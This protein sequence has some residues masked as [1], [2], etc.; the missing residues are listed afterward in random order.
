LACRAAGS[1]GRPER[2]QEAHAV[3]ALHDRAG[4]FPS[5]AGPLTVRLRRVDA[6]F[7]WTPTF[8]MPLDRD[9][10]EAVEFERFLW[11][12]C[13]RPAVEL[14]AAVVARYPGHI[15]C[16]DIETRLTFREVWAAAVRLAAIVDATVAPGAAVGV[17]LPN[18]AS[19]AVA[20]LACLGA[21][22]PCI[23]ID[24]NYPQD[25]VGRIVR[26]AGL[27]AIVLR[28]SEIAEGYLLPA[29]LKAI[30]LEQAFEPGAMLDRMPATPPAPDE[31]TFVVYT[32]GSTGG[33]KGIVLSQRAVLHRAAE[34]VNAVHL[35]PADK[36]LSLASPGTIGGLQQIFEVM[37]S[38]ASLVKLDL[39]RIGLGD[40]VRI[41]AERR[42]TMMFSTP[43]V[44][45]SVSRLDG[46]AEKLASLR[47][48][49][50]SGDTLLRIDHD[51]IRAI[52]P[53]DCHVLSVYGATEAPALLQWFVVSP[54]GDEPRVPAGYPL[55]D[56]ELAL[57]DD[58][59]RPVADGGLGEL[60]VRS[61]FTSLGL[62]QRGAVVPGVLEKD[63]HF[64]ELRLYRTGDLVRRR[65]DGLHVVIGRRDR[66]I[67]ILGNRVELAEVETALRQAP[68][69]LDAAAVA[70]RGEGEPLILGFVVPRREDDARVLEDV[71]AHLESALPGFMRPRK[72]L[73]LEALPLLPG[74]KIDEDALLERAATSGETRPGRTA[75][76]GDET[77]SQRA[78]NMV[79]NAWRIAL[80][81]A[82]PR[83]KASFEEAGGDSLQ[84]LQM[85]FELE[86]LAERALPMERFHGG[87]TVQGIA[88]E[89][90][91]CL[92]AP[93]KTLAADTATIFMFPP[94]GIDSYLT[95]FR[96]ACVARVE[97]RQVRYPE[98]RALAGPG[99]SFETIAAGTARQIGAMKPV[100]R[101]ILAGYSDGGD[102][103]YAAAR[104]L[105]AGGRDVARL[106]ILDTD[107]SGVSYAAP[108][109]ERTRGRWRLP[110]YIRHPTIHHYRR[111]VE[112]LV[113]GRLLRTATGRALLRCVLA[114]RLPIPASI[115][116]ITSL[117]AYMVVFDE[118]HRRWSGEA[119]FAP[120][121]VPMVLFRS[122]ERRPGTPDDLGWRNRTTDLT[123]VPVPG[124]HS[125][126]LGASNG[127][128]LAQEFARLASKT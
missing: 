119:D 95:E 17:L 38:G 125:T 11:E 128:A 82:P 16:E 81:L 122:Q 99:M 20:V 49:Q 66:Q 52:L 36:V 28:G 25:R 97:V 123:I 87:L 75:A 91:L 18:Q 70:R 115:A 64:P 33:P 9:G 14:F 58:A 62:W 113:P 106:L 126:M 120:L 4:T 23:L 60:V 55:P 47:C 5:A 51:Q 34:L 61:R 27:A 96:A 29:G 94:I 74:R 31:A 12:W 103:A 98:L 89:I 43:A 102:M 118:H 63:P 112:L 35:R 59:G 65:P 90:D 121:T 124:D 32:S 71:R 92:G 116:F 41:V 83:T 117:K 53:S 101:L 46:V 40:V 77:P 10:P 109:I 105:Q 80:G 100:G 78:I 39:Q 45:R 30:A 19:Y 73:A 54:P 114:F 67:K 42:I 79:D 3:W 50:S 68:G 107:A 6:N 127:T 15:A 48:I 21:A 2:L 76:G 111:L 24:R 84:L 85:I 13:E 7:N 57:L 8:A 108:A 44:W 26:D 110:S 93:T 56:I 1:H 72:L 69:V 37:L 88:H 104:H 22:R 86:R